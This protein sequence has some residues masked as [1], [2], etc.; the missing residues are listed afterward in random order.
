MPLFLDFWW[1]YKAR[2]DPFTYVLHHLWAVKS[3]DSLLV[4]H[5]QPAWQP[6]H[7]DP[8]TA[9]S[10]CETR[11]RLYRLSYTDLF[12]FKNNKLYPWTLTNGLFRTVDALFLWY[13]WNPEWMV[14]FWNFRWN[15]DCSVFQHS[16]T[17][18]EFPYRNIPYVVPLAI[19]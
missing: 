6:S 1:C 7:S 2:V 12:L 14:Q 17:N 16:T 15:I 3:S 8:C 5:L 9:A 13:L 10:L 18:Q 19:K 11:Q 4:W